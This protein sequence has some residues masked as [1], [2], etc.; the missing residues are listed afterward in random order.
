MKTAQ[1]SIIRSVK[2]KIN[3]FTQTLNN[4]ERKRETTINSIK[5]ELLILTLIEKYLFELYDKEI[6]Y[7]YIQENMREHKY[8]E[9]LEYLKK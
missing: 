8:Q 4:T 5:N 7:E 1:R 9:V 6:D 3:T 2:D